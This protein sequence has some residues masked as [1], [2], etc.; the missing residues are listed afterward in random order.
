MGKMKKK[1][2]KSSQFHDL[3][4]KSVL[5]ALP[6]Y[7][8]IQDADLNILFANQTFRDD[9][10]DAVGQPCYKVFQST[11]HKCRKCPVQKTF[12]DK[13]VH[14]AEETI[15]LKDGS[16]NEMIVYSAPLVSLTGNVTAVIKML[17]NVNMIKEVQKEL[18]TLGQSFAV[19]THDLKNM[20][21]V[22]EGGSYVIEEGIKDNDMALTRKGWHIV[23]KNI[24]EIS[25][26][27]QNILYSSKKRPPKFQKVK[28]NEIARRAVELFQEKAGT[29]EIQLISQLNPALPLEACDKDKRKTSH[30][31]FVRAE[32]YNNDFYMF[33]VEDN[34]HGMNESTE[35]NLFK[36]FFSNKGDSGT[37]L[38]LM[39]VD[40]IVKN[41][42]G[43]IEVLTKPEIGSLFRA[44]FKA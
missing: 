25:R 8:T 28:P 37:G 17:T 35:A 43:K 36:E 42:K 27:T 4:F 34:A 40:R 30:S 19:L 26:V 2:S 24:H 16:S 13:K 22:L 5:D 20:L 41:H 23:R 9:F 21:E 38:G 31:V 29:L 3:T 14:I 18:V 6:C 12:I 1:Q 32:F 33:E 7:L 11:E 39:V 10:G 44:I 15:L